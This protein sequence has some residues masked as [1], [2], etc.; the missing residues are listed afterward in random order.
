[1]KLETSDPKVIIGGLFAFIAAVMGG[2]FM[3][4]TIE[5]KEMTELRTEAALLRQQV[6]ALQADV[7]ACMEK[8]PEM[9]LPSN[10][11]EAEE[12]A[13]EAKEEADPAAPEAE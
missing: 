10:A 7:D 5:P 3:G 13:P 2:S 12:E 6:D 9:K 1:M 4:F 11:Q 8:H